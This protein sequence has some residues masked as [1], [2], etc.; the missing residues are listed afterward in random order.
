[1]AG[2]PRSHLV[3]PLALALLALTGCVEQTKPLPEVSDTPTSAPAS[4]NFPLRVE[5]TGGV[6]GFHDLL[7]IQE[8]GSVVADSKKGQVSCTIDAVSLAALSTAARAIHQN[9]QPTPGTSMADGM[10]VT[11]SARFGTLGIDDPR[12]A[13]VAPVVQQL[14]A[15]VSGPQAKRKI[16]T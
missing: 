4:A 10:S 14:L 5:R 13:D 12:V 8:D 6:A 16:C 11:F 1:M 7:V 9:D 3:V 15:D 2:M